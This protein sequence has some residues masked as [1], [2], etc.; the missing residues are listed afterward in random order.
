M[1]ENENAQELQNVNE[2]IKIRREKLANMQAEGK[3]PFQITKYDVTDHSLDAKAK[4]E[5]LDNELKTKL[6]EGL[7]EEETAEKLK[8]LHEA[9]KIEV[10]V[11]GRMMLKRVMGKAS[12]ATIRDLQGDIQLYVTRDSLGVDDYQDFKKMD[13]GDIIGIKGFAF[14]TQTGQKSIH[15][16]EL[17]LLS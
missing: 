13:I 3:D 5:K 9:Q 17:T 16:K 1:A 11:A 6:P 7:S 15:V 12:F 4:F 2:Q 14:V 10:S 8:E